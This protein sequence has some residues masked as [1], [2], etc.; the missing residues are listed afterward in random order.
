[1]KIPNT[2]RKLQTEINILIRSLLPTFDNL[3][4][5][6]Q[7]LLNLQILS[8][9]NPEALRLANQTQIT[10]LGYIEVFHLSSPNQIPANLIHFWNLLDHILW[11]FISLFSGIVYPLQL[12][13]SKWRSSSRKPLLIRR[14]C[15]H[16]LGSQILKI[17]LRSPR[18]ILI[19]PLSRWPLPFAII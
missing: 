11:A 19:W 6:G 10:K 14:H 12:C 18:H 16:F 17:V 15:V 5:L 13:I 3:F 1:M 7:R 9:K 2:D 8:I 4:E